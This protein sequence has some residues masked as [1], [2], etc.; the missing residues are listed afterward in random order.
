M[1]VTEFDFASLKEYITSSK[2]DTLRD[3]AAKEGK[4]YIGSSSSM[5]S[6][7]AHFHYLLSQWRPIDARTV[8]RGFPELLNTFTRLLRFPAAVFLR[9]KNGSYAIDA[10]KEFDNANILMSLGK[11]MEKLLTLPKEEFERYRRSSENKITREEEQAI[12]EP[13][14]YTTFGDFVMRSQLDAYDPRLPGTGMFDLKTRAVVS[15]RMNAT[16]F[17]QGLGY[18]I[19]GRY[20]TFESYEREFYDM[21]RAAFLKYSLQ[22]RI[23]R[24]DGIFVAFHNIERIFGFQYI[25]LPEMDQAL[26]SQTDTALG[27]KEFKLSLSLW[28]KVLDRATERFPEQSLRFHFETLDTANPTMYVFAEPVTDDEMHAIQTTNAER[29]EAYHRRILNLEDPDGDTDE[30]DKPSETL[31][32][33]AATGREQSNSEGFESDTP[34]DSKAPPDE[35]FIADLGKEIQQDQADKK[36]L[37][38]LAVTVKNRVNGK[39]VERPSNITADDDWEVEYEFNEIEP[40]HARPLYMACHGRRKQE[41]AGRGEDDVNH[42]SNEYIRVLRQISKAGREYR[43]EQDAIDKEKGLV[44]LHES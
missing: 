21:I 7:L 4:K 2:D 42:A 1:P 14:H 24:M 22:V 9:Y 31:Q 18:Q 26:H 27:D 23:G 25:S 35:N 36:D 15:I 44:V 32:D 28:N 10:D 17:E 6:V 40:E 37:F 11:S 8:S 19:K 38:A 39:V 12:P 43:Q 30:A 34:R 5:T 20:G 33:Q 3:I 29:I 13:Y 16:N 41:L